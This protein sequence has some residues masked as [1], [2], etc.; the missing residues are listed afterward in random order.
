MDRISVSE[1]S[2]PETMVKAAHLTQS[3]QCSVDN[4]GIRSDVGG[5][6]NEAKVVVSS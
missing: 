5:S 4:P 2:Q 6:S 3:T 1:A